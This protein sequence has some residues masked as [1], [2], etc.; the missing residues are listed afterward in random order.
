MGGGICKCELGACIMTEIILCLG[1]DLGLVFGDS[2]MLSF[3]YFITLV[4][5]RTRV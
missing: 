5:K 1:K 4:N 2:N 3:L